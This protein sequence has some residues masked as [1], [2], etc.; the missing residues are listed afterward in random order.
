[1]SLGFYRLC[2]VHPRHK[3]E[4]QFLKIAVFFTFFIYSTWHYKKLNTESLIIPVSWQTQ[5]HIGWDVFVHFSA[6][7]CG[8]VSAWA[9]LS[10]KNFWT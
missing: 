8:A 1:M 2:S 6:Y 4:M 10:K 7:I 3:W 9:I 5:V